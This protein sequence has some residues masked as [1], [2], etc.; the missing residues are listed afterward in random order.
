MPTV[1]L[2]TII[3]SYNTADLTIQ[4]IQSVLDNYQQDNISG[5]IIVVDNHSTD[6][7]VAQIRKQ[8]SKKVHLIENKKNTGFAIANNQG[9]QHATGH[10]LFLLNS[11][12]QL[13]P[14]AIKHLLSIFSKYPDDLSTA[15][16]KNASQVIDRVGMVSGKLLNP[17]SSVQP[18][19]GAL[20]SLWNLAVWWLWPLPGSFPFFTQAQYHIQDQSFFT[21]EQTTGWLGGTALLVRRSLI[22]EIG[23]L[24]ENIF[25]YAEDVDWCIRAHHHHWDVLYTPSAEITHFG[26]ASSSTEQ[27]LQKEITGLLYVTAKHWSVWKYRLLV[28][29]FRFGAALRWL[30]FGIISNNEKKQTLYAQIFHSTFPQE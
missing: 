27:S 28:W 24:D 12:T 6:H 8:F 30:L 19:G 7:S 18:Q 5:E 1:Q 2:S 15:Q 9:I 13:H 14:H 20:P 11:D 21:S 25:M 26:S 29:L 16:L 4:A 23:V 10:Y 17:D 3:V 22:D